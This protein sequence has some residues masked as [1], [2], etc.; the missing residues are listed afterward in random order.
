MSHHVT[1]VTLWQKHFPSSMAEPLVPMPQ[2][3]WPVAQPASPM[4]Q[5]FWKW[6]SHFSENTTNW[7]F[8]FP[9]LQGAFSPAQPLPAILSHCENRPAIVWHGSANCHLASGRPSQGWAK[10]ARAMAD[11]TWKG[12]GWAKFVPSA[13]GFS[14][15]TEVE[16]SDSSS[17]PTVSDAAAPS[18][19]ASPLRKHMTA[20]RWRVERVSV[21]PAV[22]HRVVDLN[23]AVMINALWVE[24]DVVELCVDKRFMFTK[25]F[26]DG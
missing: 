7:T 8:I 19:L 25:L 6:L 9:T 18:P 22:I 13:R 20:C 26:E 12:D 11:P 3:F 10:M 23:D 21:S 5:P 2:P 17:F 14:H 15:V 24:E 4:P 16:A 1:N